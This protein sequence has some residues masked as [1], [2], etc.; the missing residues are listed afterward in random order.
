MSKSCFIE[1]WPCIHNLC[2][3]VAMN[4]IQSLLIIQIKGFVLK[5]KKLIS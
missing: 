3:L 2:Q 5:K 1:W 4:S